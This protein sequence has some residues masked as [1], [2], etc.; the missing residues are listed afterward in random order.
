MNA[1]GFQFFLRW[2]CEQLVRA[3]LGGAWR[4]VV[5][6]AGDAQD[7]A[8]AR[9][10]ALVAAAPCWPCYVEFMHTRVMPDRAMRGGKCWQSLLIL[11]DAE[12]DFF[13]AEE[14]L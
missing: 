2:W 12:V 6:R 8:F 5:D 1:V 3:L 11:T 13:E 4:H 9:F 10:T 14:D 7:R